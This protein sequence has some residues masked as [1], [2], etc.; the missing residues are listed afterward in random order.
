MYGVNKNVLSEEDLQPYLLTETQVH[1]QLNDLSQLAGVMDIFIL[2]SQELTEYYFNVDELTFQHGD[3]LNYMAQRVGR[4]VEQVILDTYSKFNGDII[5]HL[6]ALLSG[7]SLHTDQD[8]L[9]ELVEHHLKQNSRT[10]SYPFLNHLVHSIIQRVTTSRADEYYFEIFRSKS[11][12]VL[13]AFI[14]TFGP[15]SQ[16]R[17]FLYGLGKNIVP[18]AKKLYRNGARHLTLNCLD[19]DSQTLADDLNHWISDVLRA[20]LQRSFFSADHPFTELYYLSM[21]DGIYIDEDLNQTQ[22]FSRDSIR[23]VNQSLEKIKQIRYN[24]K[25]QVFVGLDAHTSRED[26]LDDCQ[27]LKTFDVNDPISLKR[28]DDLQKILDHYLAQAEGLKKDL[29]NEYHKQMAEA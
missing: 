14:Q 4:P 22:E 23:W 24:D 11:D 5:S 2:N 17:F 15:I 12:L 19:Q 3:F 20:D 26:L 25:L 21:A 13:Q 18:L 16:R 1:D 10:Q 27:K 6:Y 9:L 7:V 8:Q 28:Q 29:L